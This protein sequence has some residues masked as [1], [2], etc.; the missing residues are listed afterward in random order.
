M[1]RLDQLESQSIYIFREAFNRIE[2]IA[3]LWSL[4]KDSN[5][6]VWLAKKAFFGHVPF[7]VAHLDTG[8]EFDETYEFRDRYVKEWGLNFIGDPCP[9]IEAIDDTL[10]PASR[11]AARKTAGVKEVIQKYG[12][13]GIIA[14]IRR[15][16]QSM[17]AKERYFSPRGNDGKWD[18]RDQPPEFWDQFNTDYPEGTHI[19]IHPLLH[20]TELDI[21]RYIQREEIPLVPLYFAKNGKRFRSL[22]EKGITEP[23][24]SDAD[25]IEKII[26]ELETIK[27]EER[28][29][30]VMDHDSED[31]FERLREDGYM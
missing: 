18:F 5:V 13:N 17:R 15:D 11:L 2:N 1:D 19:R 31:A 26:A 7:P 24:A 21:W 23:F 12:F 29:G 25:T 22:G 30:R 14:G 28:A 8:L 20:W 27:T 3:M 4:G 9:P 6:M 10:P 16:E